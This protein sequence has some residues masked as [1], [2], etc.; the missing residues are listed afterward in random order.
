MA[1]HTAKKSSAAQHAL[2]CAGLTLTAA[3]AALG[4]GAVSAGEAEPAAAPLASPV[5]DLDAA[6]AGGGV[7]GALHTATQG[8]LAPVKH[9]KINPL[10]G[11]GVDPLDNAIGTQVADFQPASTAVATGPLAKGGAL[12]DLPLAGP[13]TGLLPG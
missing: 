4:G 11:T 13:A 3:G 9:L 1:R 2:L 10:A 6:A 7:T 8:G 12:A 5:G